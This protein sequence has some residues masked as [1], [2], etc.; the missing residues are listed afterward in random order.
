MNIGP[1]IAS[2]KFAIFSW[3]HRALPSRWRRNLPRKWQNDEAPAFV[4]QSR[5]YG[6]AGEM[7]KAESS[8]NAQITKE[9][10]ERRR[11]GCPYQQIERGGSGF[12]IPS[13]LDIRH[14]RMISILCG[15]LWY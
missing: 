1:E 10:S 9:R 2:K 8:P 14:C 3:A 6:T 11:G 15:E 7:T 13:S 5:D 12:V 4:P